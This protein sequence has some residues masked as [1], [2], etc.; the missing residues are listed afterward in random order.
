MRSRLLSFAF[1]LGWLGSS[2]IAAEIQQLRA[3]WNAGK[4]SVAFQ[5]NSPFDDEQ[6]RQ[7]LQGGL[8]TGF[9]YHVELIRKRPNWFDDTLDA[10][11]IEVVAT[12]NSVTREYLI[13]YRKGRRL[14]RSETVSDFVSLQQRMTTVAEEALLNAGR[15]SP[16]KL[17]V[18]VRADLLRGYLF[19]VIP[20][21][22]STNW[23]E[24]RVR[25]QAQIAA[26]QA[27]QAVPRQRP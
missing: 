14:V 9:T 3:A 6:I 26:P 25:R 1:T 18:R 27:P 5:L 13:N 23:K 7:A 15:V 16:S 19:H 21:D 11:R 24:V 8:P 22:V 2:L 17:R 12:L 10:E 20:W 4:V